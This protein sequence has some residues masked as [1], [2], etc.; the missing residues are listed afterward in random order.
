MHTIVRG[1][2]R[3]LAALAALLVAQVAW[4]EPL[5]I[6]ASSERMRVDGALREWRGARFAELGSGDD[7]SVRYALASAGG[8]L[9]VGA[10]VRDEALV[11][12]TSGDALVLTLAMPNGERWDATELW[13]RPGESGRSKASASLGEKGKAEPRVQVV[14]GPRTNGP[15]YVLEAFIPWSVVAGAQIWEQGR[16]GLRLVDV[17][18][19]DRSAEST[20]SSAQATSASELPRLALGVG[21]NDL[22]GS[23]LAAKK[24]HGVEPRFDFRA[25]V[26]GDAQ[27]ERVA[28][29]GEYVVVYGPGYKRGETYGYFA[30]PYSTGGGLKS[31]EVR[32]LTGDGLAELLVVVRQRNE[33]GARELWLALTLVE[34]A[35]APLFGLELKK[36]L[37]GGFVENVLAV[38]AAS[39]PRIHAR[40]GR[41]QGL[42]ANTYVEQPASDAQPIL[43][44]W[45]EVESRSFAW[46][47]SAF[48][49]VDEKRR[50]KAITPAEPAL[51]ERAVAGASEVQ[52][53][54]KP[55]L[56]SV[57]A[58]FKTQQKLPA[59]A[60]P[61]RTV[62]A[63]LV[64]G[65]GKEQVHLFG[66]VLAIVGPDVAGGAGYLAYGIP[67]GDARDVLD[68]SV[69][70]VTGDAR[71]ELLVRV[72][73]P[74]RGAAA[75]Q[76]ELLIVLRSDGDRIVRV[77]TAEIK[78][79][80]EGGAIENRVRAERGA[81]VIEP[82]TARGWSAETYPF[83]A[84]AVGGVA[85][86]LLPWRDRA[87]RYALRGDALAPLP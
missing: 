71:D 64:G 63:N 12:G 60:K 30:L 69:A 33:L 27:P 68:L 34:E 35:I 80:A 28:I 79:V 72:R 87:V 45:G 10:E 76:R 5:R 77:L 40:V 42:D 39:P 9:Y 50:A 16:G 74:L 67:V 48:A 32:D 11:T 56:G 86:L 52:T 57:L 3:G 36:E 20:K 15:G 22:L 75:A 46:N 26:A 55:E 81:L 66:S 85:P 61:T 14:E 84:D 70:E 51:R 47:G 7:A 83:A 21:Q 78:R 31:A 73:Q 44:P 4:A 25:N 29:I 58:L 53:A 62:A 49:V 13:L 65:S 17:D 41:A 6:D 82:G 24:M 37:K 43:L 59:A 19:K 38:Q 1:V 18:V 8:G 2:S 54:V 23:F